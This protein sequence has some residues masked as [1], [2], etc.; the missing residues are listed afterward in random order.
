MSNSYL[1]I[2]TFLFTTLFYY[3]AIKPT[4]TYDV[5]VDPLKYKQY[6]SN[7]YM[8][9]AIYLL[10]VIVIQFMVNS[11][12]IS[13]TCG[14]NITENMGA[15]GIFTFLPWVFIFGVL[16]IVLIVYPGFKR[17]FS[18]VIG[19][20]WVAS[21]TNTL[22]TELLIN[23]E[24][25]SNIDESIETP[26]QK[27]ALQSAADTILK[28]CGNTSI[29]INQIVPSNFNSYWNLLTPLIKKDNSTNI[30]LKNKLFELVVTRDNIGESMWYIYTGLLVTLIIQL[31]I[32][33][34]GCASNHKTMEQKYQP[35][36]DSDKQ[37]KQK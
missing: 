11:Y 20:F 1:N 16:M 5:L 33:T 32:A 13:T 8:F 7:S 30:D 34:T 28:I 18:D 22:L 25:Q 14:G 19:Y 12:I 21:S 29:L 23:P 17:A 3:L 6:M 4:L 2:V 36:L 15:A 24:I 26:E 10:L 27:I 31:K 35:F 9:L 37:A